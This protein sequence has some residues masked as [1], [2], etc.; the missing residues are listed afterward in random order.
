MCMYNRTDILTLHILSTIIQSRHQNSF[1]LGFRIKSISRIYFL[2][3]K[4]SA[5]S[6]INKNKV[7]GYY[8]IK[9]W[10]GVCS[11]WILSRPGSKAI[12]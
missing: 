12:A 2:T 7:A 8:V 1:T 11:S 6:S 4:T 9:E 10:L 5:T 3:K